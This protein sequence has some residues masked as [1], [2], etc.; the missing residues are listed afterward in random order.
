MSIWYDGRFIPCWNKKHYENLDW[1]FIKTFGVNPSFDQY[2]NE[3]YEHV[4]GNDAYFLPNKMPE[5]VDKILTN[6][7]FKNYKIKTPGFHR[8]RPGMILP[9]HK[10][11]YTMFRKIYNIDLPDN[12]V[13]YIIF[14]E[15]S[16][17]GHMLQ[18]EDEVITNYDSG[19]CFF[20][21]G[22]TE[23]AAFNLGTEDRFT[24]QITCHE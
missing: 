7:L 4:I 24:L 9:L 21:K 16:K 12:I 6:D 15:Q 18:I 19:D 20:W 1:T 23:H 2:N 3:R 10:D 22:E 13:R 5:F 11:P 17:K 8:L 14:L